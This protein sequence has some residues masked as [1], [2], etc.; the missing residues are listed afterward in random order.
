M[1]ILDHGKN[2][3]CNGA[4]DSSLK[5]YWPTSWQSS[6]QLLKDNG[7]KDPKEFFICL[8][9]DHPCSYDIVDSSTKRCHY[10][11][12]GQ[13]TYIKYSYLPLKDKIERWCSNPDFCH[14]MTAH[15]VEREYWLG[16]MASDK[17]KHKKEVWDGARF[18]E[19]SWFWDPSCEWV[20]PAHCPSCKLDVGAE[21]LEDDSS[22]TNVMIECP[23]CHFEFSH[24][25]K[26]TFGD[27]IGHWDGWQPFSSSSRHTSGRVRILNLTSLCSI[28]S[29]F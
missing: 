2:L 15:W 7:Y 23:E 3:Y 9:D 29:I 28:F 25:I 20:L 16:S 8:S 11:D 19:L 26:T 13:S 21:V 6:M 4:N 1:S 10:C 12:A 18:K 14:R 22:T 17:G 5:G 24:Q 27:P